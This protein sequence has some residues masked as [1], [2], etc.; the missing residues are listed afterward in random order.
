[1]GIVVDFY[2]RHQVIRGELTA[3]HGRLL[4]LLNNTM[5]KFVV[6]GSA[7]SKSLHVA[8]EPIKLGPTRLHKDQLLL[9]VPHDGAQ[10][11]AAPIRGGWVE[12]R[13]ARVT[14]GVGP[15][16]VSGNMHF[17]QWEYV[18]LDRIARDIDGRAFLPVTYARITSLYH[19]AWV[20]EAK[21]VLVARAAMAYVS[22]PASSADE[23]QH[24]T[25]AL[26]RPGR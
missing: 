4:D 23:A 7:L 13:S 12:K 19:P 22:L 2:L 20:V 26:V 24:N 9:A 17:G 25:Q 3:D 14:V 15:L 6:L 18:T 21:S 5:E 8:A 1:M 16:I 10:A 11:A